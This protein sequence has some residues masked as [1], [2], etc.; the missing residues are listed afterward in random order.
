[1]K[2]SLNMSKLGKCFLPEYS[3]CPSNIIKTK[4][5]FNCVN[6]ICWELYKNLYEIYQK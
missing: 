5:R 2:I 3:D 6:Q 4:D 1:M